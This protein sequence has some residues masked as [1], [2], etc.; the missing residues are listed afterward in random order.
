MS[1]Q[2]FRFFNR[3]I[4]LRHAGAV[5]VGL[6]VLSL[7]AFAGG[8]SRDRRALALASTSETEPKELSWQT[9]L[10]SKDEP[11]TPL[12]VTGRIFAPDGKTPVEGITLHVYHTDAR[13]LY[14]EEDGKGGPPNPRL[15]GWM[16]TDREGRYEF[17]TIRPASYPNSRNPQHIHAKV[18]GAGHAERWIPEYWFADDPLVTDDMRAKHSGEGAFTPIMSATRGD[19]GVL[20]CVRDIK[21]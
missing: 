13:G 9:V 1:A 11:G 6:P 12:V 20:R 3:R 4:F 16:Q 19:D 8:C 5:L 14:S 18:Y 10:V 21:L 15:K 2:E 17:R 7:S